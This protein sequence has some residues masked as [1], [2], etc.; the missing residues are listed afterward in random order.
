MLN[1]DIFY[2]DVF[3]NNMSD[4]DLSHMMQDILSSV[5]EKDFAHHF[6]VTVSAAIDK[7]FT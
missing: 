1:E 2:A 3:L 7:Y 5:A 6:T 4:L